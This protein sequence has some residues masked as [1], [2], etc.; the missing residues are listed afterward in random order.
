MAGS[1]QDFVTAKYFLELL[2]KELGIS[3]SET[4]PEP[5]YSAGTP[6]SRNAT[7]SIPS[8]HS[9]TAWIDVYYP[10]MNTPLDR[11][12]EILDDDGNVIWSANVEEVA[13]DTDP[14][15]GR[16]AEAVPAWHGLSRGGEATG[17]LV[18]AHYGRKQDYDA[19]VAKGNYLFP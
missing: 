1:P 9:P 7:L 4:D 19:L 18:Y 15:A 12:L 6:D 13:D 16:Y 10:V 17:K 11:S 3:P 2:Q 14:E 8:L 5:V